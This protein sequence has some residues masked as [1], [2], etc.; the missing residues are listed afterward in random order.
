MTW[1]GL[2]FTPFNWQEVYLAEPA[3]LTLLLIL[4]ILWI[5]RRYW[6]GQTDWA[7]FNQKR[8]VKFRHSLIQK[9]NF[10]QKQPGLGKNN[11]FWAFLMHLLRLFILI[12]LTLAMANPQRQEK[13][14]LTPQTET[15]RDIVFVVESSVSFSLNDYQLNGK[16][17]KRMTV[18]KSVLDN[19]ISQLVGNRFS[20]ILFADQAY[21][22]MPITSDSTTARLMLKRLRPYL[23][24]RGD[25]GMGEAL[26][27]ALEQ[28]KQSTKTTQKRIVVLISDGLSRKSKIPIQ[29]V[30][31]YAKALKIPIYTI[32]VGA[33][34][35]SA[36]KR[37]YSGLIYQ[38]LD[39]SM[40]KIIAQK[41]GGKYF[42]IGGGK[43]LSTVLNAISRSEGVQIKTPV[44][45]H[46][47]IHLAPLLLLLALILLGVYSLLLLAGKPSKNT[48]ETAS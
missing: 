12:A 28:A 16:P 46:K 34:N 25:E 19:F 45:K 41:T 29:N 13:L 42:Q 23:A 21:T 14:S 38:T 8:S 32:G 44:L 2:D 4:P 31:G 36:D 27:L 9:A 48:Q 47:I 26:G 11:I 22:L 24:G 15:V 30:I 37:L 18:V 1:M 5:L 35:A 33:G 43:Q 7:H 6:P 20:W 39:S 17:A 40:L 3:W 10:N